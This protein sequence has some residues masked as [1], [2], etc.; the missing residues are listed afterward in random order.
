V[1]RLYRLDAQSLW[2]DE[3]FTWNG[4]HVGERLQLSHVL[5]NLHG[6]LY[7]LLL[8]VWTGV[9]GGGEWALRFPSA[10][11]GV[12]LVWAM[13]W[14]AE[15]WLGREAALPAAWLAAASPF[16]VWYGQ[17]AR[18]YTMVMLC[19]TLST[20]LLVE[21]AAR[22]RARSW[23]AYLGWAWAGLMSNLSFLLL[24]PFH[25]WTLLRAEPGG[26][27]RLAP[28][29]AVAVALALLALP[30]VP[31][32]ART[33]A[34]YRLNPAAPPESRAENLRGVPSFHWAALPFTWLSFST[35]YTL[36]PSL[37]ELRRSPDLRPAWRHA[38]ELGLAAAGFVPLGVAGLV[39]LGRRRRLAELAL[40]LLAPVALLSC[41]AIANVKPFNPRYLAVCLPG[42]LLLLAAG[43]TALRPR[44]RWAVGALVA[45]AWSVALYRHYFVPDYGKEDYRAAAGVLRAE[46][47]PGELVLAAG[48]QEPLFYYYRGPL[49][50]E[51]YW[52]GFA[53]HPERMRAKFAA[54]LEGRGSAWVV[55]ARPEHWDPE[56]RFAE[57][58]DHAFP[59]A[60]RR[61]WVGVT[62]WHLD[63]P[64][65]GWGAAR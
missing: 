12:G 56:G 9:A 42:Y 20:G 19:V 44:W 3:V 51:R 4:A 46:G 10:L 57:W 54:A 16:L 15:R 41:L 58:L 53:A 50:V 5:E 22:R 1:L 33:L 48:A 28:A 39:A 59:A 52:L 7:A 2:V 13:A 38:P 40:W 49:P 29:A 36:G 43:W 21:W 30:W 27:R 55:L 31:Q 23:A 37:R 11:L 65:G 14:L 18:N 6:P 35:G 60:P 25:G 47:R 62:V 26:R 8:N 34:W 32:V 63:R 64:G 45:A 17:E 61:E 24:A